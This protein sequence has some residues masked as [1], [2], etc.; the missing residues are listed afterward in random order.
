[1]DHDPGT[2]R[3]P[4]QGSYNREP[5]ASIERDRNRLREFQLEVSTGQPSGQAWLAIRDDAWVYGVRTVARMIRQ[6][7]VWRRY[8]ELGGEAARD[9]RMP[10]RGVSDE[11]AHTLASL[12][13]ERALAVLRQQLLENKWC[14]DRENPASI[15][16]WFVNLV[17]L[18]LRTPWRAW[19][20]Q[21]RAQPI[22][23]P[24]NPD[25]EI[26]LRDRPEA[27]IYAVE[28]DRYLESLD[29][30]I[31]IMIRLD[32]AQFEDAEIA[33]LVGRTAKGVEYH[34]AKSRRAARARRDR[35]TFRDH[36][37]GAA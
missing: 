2:S 19:R 29:P 4:R 24:L 20:R 6:G 21:Q 7:V 17:V 11:D 12:A 13:V 3:Q 25:R 27:V 30:E 33:A 31:A 15:N 23:V 32:A 22:F 14:P 28:F 1:M 9:L 16:T 18:S 35:E 10:A 36:S 26:D 5:G 34:L 8:R 37:T